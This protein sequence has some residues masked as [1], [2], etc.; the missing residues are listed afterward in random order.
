[1]KPNVLSI[2]V[3]NSARSQ[4]AEA[5]VNKICGEFFQTQSAG[6]EPG[7]LNPLAVEVMREVGIDISKKKTFADGRRLFISS[8]VRQITPRSAKRLIQDDDERRPTN[9]RKKSATRAP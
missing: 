1:M 3:H 2:C 5:W 7:S 6:L 9:T 8:I 4:M